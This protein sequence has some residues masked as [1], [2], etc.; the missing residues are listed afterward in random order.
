LVIKFLSVNKGGGTLLIEYGSFRALFPFG[1][2]EADRQTWRQGMDLGEVSVLYLADNGY[3]SS[4]PSTWIRNLNPE[5]LLL[6]VG[7]K[8]SQGLPDRELIARLGG[9]SLLRTDQHGT[10]HLISDGV[11]MWIRV[12]SL[13]G[14]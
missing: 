9:Y 6:S 3:Q 14:L 12:D 11:R 13:D 1:I 7:L 2:V 4:N 10:I 5:L 8:D